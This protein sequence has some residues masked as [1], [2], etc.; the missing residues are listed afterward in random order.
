MSQISH[1][2]R[3]A[4]HGATPAAALRL[5]QQ[6]PSILRRPVSLKAGTLS[7]DHSEDYETIEHLFLAC[8]ETGDE[9]SAMLCLDRLTE[10]FG[11]SNDRVTGLRGLYDEAI[12]EGH[13]D[14]EKCLREYE[15]L[16]SANPVNVVCSSLSL[17]KPVTD[18]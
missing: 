4:L 15:K 2:S 3:N 6:A 10:W 16:L 17:F 13:L 5:S 11:H 12:A 14:M 9:K 7:L 18:D 8:L 1:V